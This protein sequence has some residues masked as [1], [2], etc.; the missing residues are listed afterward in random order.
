[1]SASFFEETLN[2]IC[3]A[4][5]KLFSLYHLYEVRVFHIFFLSFSVRKFLFC[6]FPRTQ[7]D[8]PDLHSQITVFNFDTLESISLRLSTAFRV[9]LLLSRDTS[10][11]LGR[12]S[13]IKYSQTIQPEIWKICRRTH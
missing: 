1:M 11:T 3:R 5:D 7:S 12:I 13:F 4:L 2:F 8:F 10:G 9:L 6:V